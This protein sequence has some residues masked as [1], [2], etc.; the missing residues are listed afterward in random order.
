MQTV[1]PQELEARVESRYRVF[2]ILWVALFISVMLFL[3]L[4]VAV[5]SNGSPNPALSY[6][7]LSFGLTMA[8]VSFVLKLQ[9]ARKA[10]DKNDIAAL[11]SAQIVSL[12]LCESTA[13]FGLLDRFTTASN[14]G[15]FLFAISAAGMLLHFPKK[16]HV[17]AVSFK[18]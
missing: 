6:G 14:T 17:R 7:L 11:Q 10:I 3:A 15:W 16:D 18:Q 8:V 13:L 5:G 2:L 12:A 9:L 1:S 4:A